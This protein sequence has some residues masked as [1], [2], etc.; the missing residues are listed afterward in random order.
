MTTTVL[1]L[2]GML[3]EMQEETGR[4]STIQVNAMRRAIE[5]AIAYY[6]S[7]RFWF[8]ETRAATFNTVIGT[9]TYTFN[10]AT[11]VGTIP[12]EFYQIDG[13]WMT[14][15]TGAVRQLDVEDYADFEQ[16][17]DSQIS[18]APPTA[19]GFIKSAIRFNYA[20]DAVYSTRIAGHYALPGPATDNETDNPWMT[21]AYYLIK[22][23]SKAELFAHRWDDYVAASAM[24]TAEQIELA[25]LRE[26]TFDKVRTGYIRAMDF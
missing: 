14:F 5:Q 26:A 13:V 6:Q 20:P 18:N 3:A 12:Y 8:N 11:T 24:Q 23:R 25:S 7:T 21:E 1:T 22:S 4:T 2:G 15:A 16:E 19:Y 9:D 10:T 17:S